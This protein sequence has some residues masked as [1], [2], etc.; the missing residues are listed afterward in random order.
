MSQSPSKKL[1]IEI[2]SSSC[3]SSPRPIEDEA[4]VME[5][6]KENE[7]ITTVEASQEAIPKEEEGDT[8]MVVE[9]SQ[10]PEDV[11][12]APPSQ[13]EEKKQDD[14]VT[15]QIP[16]DEA[17]QP[18]F[19]AEV[20]PAKEEESYEE[21][22]AKYQEGKVVPGGLWRK[23]CNQGNLVGFLYDI[24]KVYE[25]LDDE[26]FAKEAREG[27]KGEKLYTLDGRSI[28]ELELT[29]GDEVLVATL[30]KLKLAL[31]SAE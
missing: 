11:P 2:P 16:E 7:T 22:K 13:E 20:E 1:R 12:L 8:T 18:P 5:E 9:A 4:P 21:M 19:V 27:F 31:V 30:N 26:T 15:S 10:I 3:P 17:T 23:A 14:L 28:L 25:G 29:E 24:Y 6:N